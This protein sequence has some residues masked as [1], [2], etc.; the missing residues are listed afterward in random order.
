[1]S[2]LVNGNNYTPANPSSDIWV[3]I[4]IEFP[5][6]LPSPLYPLM[7]YSLQTGVTRKKKMLCASYT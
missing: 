3:D 7:E 2:L 5:N 4:P 1:M 6:T